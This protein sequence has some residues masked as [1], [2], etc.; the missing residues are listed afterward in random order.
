MT[1]VTYAQVTFTTLFAVHFSFFASSNV[2]SIDFRCPSSE[3]G[4]G[5]LTFA[6]V[7]RRDLVDTM[8]DK[9][10]FGSGI[11]SRIGNVV[12][13]VEGNFSSDCI[14][15]SDSEGSLSR[16]PIVFGANGGFY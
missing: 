1:V 9:S 15:S 6:R 7:G 13:T 10:E 4:K 16:E 14:I 5:E 8:G 3:K 11:T 12:F 2:E